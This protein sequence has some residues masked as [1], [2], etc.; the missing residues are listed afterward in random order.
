[1]SSTCSQQAPVEVN[2]LEFPLINPNG[3]DSF[4]RV[5]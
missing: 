1:M 5:A 2:A 3:I 4:M